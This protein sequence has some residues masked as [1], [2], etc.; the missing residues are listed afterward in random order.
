VADEADTRPRDVVR[1]DGDH[2]V[3]SHGASLPGVCVLCGSRHDIVRRVEVL[4][5]RRPGWRRIVVGAFGAALTSMCFCVP[6]SA[7]WP[8]FVGALVVAVW[9]A[10]YAL[11]VYLPFCGA[12]DAEWRRVRRVRSVATLSL[13]PASVLAM[14]ALIADARGALPPRLGAL[15]AGTSTLGW[16]AAFVAVR[17]RTRGIRVVRAAAITRD[18]VWLRG[19]DPDAMREIAAEAAAVR[20]AIGPGTHDG[21]GLGPAPTP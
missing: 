13:V 9:L 12:C 20:P 14:G 11:G 7:A 15:L 18:L 19:V 6:P 1:I 8:F 4:R 10:S 16:L 2:L 17:V 21:G 5:V 3:I